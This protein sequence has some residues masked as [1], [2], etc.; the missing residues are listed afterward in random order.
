MP[1]VINS[2]TNTTL[3][4]VFYSLKK[5]SSS[6]F[7]LSSGILLC[8]LVQLGLKASENKPEDYT[9]FVIAVLVLFLGSGIVWL[10][11]RPL[12]QR[13]LAKKQ[14]EV[15]EEWLEQFQREG[16]IDENTLKK[17]KVRMEFH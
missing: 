1:S 2:L 16:I 17:L 4:G 7:L 9:A 8:L 3:R 15:V 5:I 11:V 13:R 12:H 6:I 14:G 10:I